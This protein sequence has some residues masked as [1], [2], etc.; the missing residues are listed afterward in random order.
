MG[1]I[2]D[3]VK[4]GQLERDIRPDYHLVEYLWNCG[5]LSKDVY[6]LELSK[7]ERPD[8]DGLVPLSSGTELA[9][10]QE[11]RSNWAIVDL[12]KENRGRQKAQRRR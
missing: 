10:A 6:N 3:H 5:L 1:H 11:N 2:Y 4:S 7:T 8:C 12:A 9:K